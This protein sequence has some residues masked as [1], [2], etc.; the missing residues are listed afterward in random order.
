M[1]LML[2]LKFPDLRFRKDMNR[3]KE[4]LIFKIIVSTFDKFTDF[5]ATF[6]EITSSSVFCAMFIT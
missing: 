2:N 3:Y 4:N 6:K 1:F 5:V